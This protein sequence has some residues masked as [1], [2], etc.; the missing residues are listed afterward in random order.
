MGQILSSPVIDKECHQGIDDL[1]SFG[2][3]SMQG[4]RMSMEDAHV[5]ELNIWEEYVSQENQIVN[6]ASIIDHLA[7]YGIFYGHGSSAVAKFCGSQFCI[8]FK[9][10]LIESLKHC[11]TNEN[12]KTLHFSPTFNRILINSIIETFQITDQRILTDQLYQNDYSGSTCTCVLISKKIETVICANAG[13]SR[14]VL[15]INGVAKTLSFDHKPDLVNERSRII[16][17]SGFVETG[18]VNGNLALS[19]AIG[20][21]E[22]KTNDTVS[23]EEQVVTSFPD[24]LIHKINYSNDDFLILACDG[25]WECLTSQ[26]C[27]NMVYR[28]IISTETNSLHDIASKIVDIC[29]APSTEGS[30]I[31][32]DNMTV[33]IVALLQNGETEESWFERIKQKQFLQKIILKEY[34]NENNNKKKKKKCDRKMACNEESCIERSKFDIP[35]FESMRRLIYSDFDFDNI[36]NIDSVNKLTAN[37]NE[38]NNKNNVFSITTKLKKDKLVNECKLNSSFLCNSGKEIN[39]RIYNSGEQQQSDSDYNY[40]IMNF[41]TLKQLLEAGVYINCHNNDN[42]NQQI[43]NNEPTPGTSSTSPQSTI[44]NIRTSLN[45]E[46]TDETD[47]SQQKKEIKGEEN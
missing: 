29:C 32:C 17:A 7:L 23:A 40:S 8:I 1:S 36:P 21:F 22:F 16:A 24:I 46:M 47:E 9:E 31:G 37:D 27:V 2:L 12:S 38:S 14:S 19:R 39:E 34:N 11:Q 26:E 15:A 25:I 20:D 4:W 35:T 6:E 3:C 43:N 5:V 28:G 18:R 30:G 10:Q 45:K 13:D 33:I 42:D 41:D 44:L